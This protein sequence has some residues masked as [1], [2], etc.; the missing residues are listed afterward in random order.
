M[1][2]IN[3]KHDIRL[4]QNQ[5][6]PALSSTSDLADDKI[7]ERVPNTIENNEDESLTRS[8]FTEINGE[9]HLLHRYRETYALRKKN[10]VI[11]DLLAD[12][13]ILNHKLKLEQ[14]QI[15]ENLENHKTTILE[16]LSETKFIVKT[17]NQLVNGNENLR[18][19]VEDLNK[20]IEKLKIELIEKIV[21]AT[22]AKRCL[23]NE[24]IAI[25]H[26]ARAYEIKRQEIKTL[27]CKIDEAEKIVR[28][29]KSRCE[30]FQSTGATTTM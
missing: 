23:A 9:P 6:F 29:L 25:E 5:D 28:D 26:L 1:T 11:R 13:E 30:Y 8:S 18:N 27:N 21:I 10:I 17:I 22:G 3:S 19:K 14:Q 20:E 7:D 16:K 15:V 4:T 2:L 12:A 24:E